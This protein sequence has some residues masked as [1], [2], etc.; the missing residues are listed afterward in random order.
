[1][2]AI[3]VTAGTFAVAMVIWWALVNRRNAKIARVAPYVA[4]PLPYARC[5]C[6]H[7][8][9]D[10]INGTDMCRRLVFDDNLATMPRPCGCEAYQP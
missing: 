7:V 4:R 9:S 2:S 1:M 3:L 8:K 10:H 5:G 6:D